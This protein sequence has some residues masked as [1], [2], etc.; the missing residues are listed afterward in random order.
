V[1]RL[2]AQQDP[3]ADSRLGNVAAYRLRGG[4]ELSPGAPGPAE[5][6]DGRVRVQ[7]QH[8]RQAGAQRGRL[9]GHYRSLGFRDGRSRPATSAMPSGLPSRV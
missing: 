3:H 7:R 2:V 9:A 8:P 4:G 5:L 1:R 6:D